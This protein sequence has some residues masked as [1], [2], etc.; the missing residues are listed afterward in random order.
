MSYTRLYYYI[1]KVKLFFYYTMD[2]SKTIAGITPLNDND[3]EN[4]MK[5]LAN[6]DLNDVKDITTKFCLAV[7]SMI[8][9]SQQ[10]VSMDLR[11]K[12][13]YVNENDVVELDRMKR[14][15][16]LAPVEEM[17]IR[18]KDK[19]WNVREHIINKNTKFFL[20]RDYSAIIKKDHNQSVIEGI[21]HIIKNSFNRLSPNEQEFYWNKAII[22]LNCVSRL[23]KILGED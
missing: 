18:A 20:D 5:K 23:K 21:I 9:A 15:I 4:I 13:S 14:I 10:K 22:M 6:A 19:V 16:N 17:I 8:T 1:L 2:E 11:N 12:M 7:K 3:V